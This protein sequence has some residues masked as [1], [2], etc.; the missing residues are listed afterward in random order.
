MESVIDAFYFEPKDQDAL[1]EEPLVLHLR[2]APTA[3]DKLV[4]FVHGLGGSRYGK[5]STWG[6]FPRFLFED[7]AEIDVGMYQY[8]TALGR[9][10][11]NRSVSLPDEAK[12]FADHV[13]DE[14]RDYKVI[15]LVGH[16]MGGL[17]CKAV[18]HRLI[19]GG[20][21]NTLARI[22]GLVLMATPQLGS[23]RM[24]AVAA[25][26]S[27]DA[28]ALKPHGEF[29]TQIN[30]AFEDH[31]ALDENVHTLRKV[32]IPTW[33]VE[34]ISDFWVDA[35]SSG[36]GLPSS[37]RKVVRGSHTSI[38]KPA[39]K[40]ADTYGWVL[41][42]IKTAL[43]R[44]EFDVFIA[45]AMAGHE[46]DTAYQANRDVVM[47]LIEVLKKDCGC[48][49]VFY[50]GTQM[51]S[52]DKF[53]PE[54]LALQMDLTALRKSRNFILYYPEKLPSSALYEAGWALVLGKPSLYLTGEGDPTVT[55]LP[56]LLDDAAQAF[57]ERRVRI[58][59]CPD[60]VSMLNE[61]RKYG[62]KLFQYGDDGGAF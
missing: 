24:P 32:T 51:P 59:R 19:Q 3:N 60:G 5:S 28:R 54:T 18:I 52:M 61:V 57:R 7:L 1:A 48:P 40:N 10:A 47:S 2:K 34:G 50:A 30:R 37:R 45:A 6:N 11:F 49:E 42:R 36:I 58:F 44:Y 15:V 35:L 14:L 55:G 22:G 53:D 29:V 56:F 62:T 8:R 9:L 12:V 16:S 25:L 4:I 41:D 20:D 21:R 46:G 43:H 13:R 23:L 33:A 17:L 27:A 39:S 38:V 26:F 31:V